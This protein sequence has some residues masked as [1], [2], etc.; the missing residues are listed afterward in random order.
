MYVRTRPRRIMG[1][2]GLERSGSLCMAIPVE[3]K[4]SNV[5]LRAFDHS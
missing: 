3:T 1:R 4:R 2:G 5:T